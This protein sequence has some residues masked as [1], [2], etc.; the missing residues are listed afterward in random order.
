MPADAAPVSVA[1]DLETI[2]QWSPGDYLTDQAETGRLSFALVILNQPIVDAEG[3][4]KLWNNGKYHPH[5]FNLNLTPLSHSPLLITITTKYPG[6]A[7]IPDCI[8]GDLDSLQSR[9]GNYYRSLGVSIVPD[10]SQYATDFTKSLNWITK[11]ERLARSMAT[12][13][14]LDDADADDADDDDDDADSLRRR[15]CNLAAEEAISPDLG[16]TPLDVVAYGAT[17]GR[18]DQVFHAIDQLFRASHQVSAADGDEGDGSNSNSNYSN[19]NNTTS[20]ASSRRKLTLISDESVTF[21]L[22]RGKNI[23]D[24]P[25]KLFGKTCGLIPVAGPSVITTE[26]FEWDLSN[27]ETRFGGMVSTSN[28]LLKDRVEVVTTELLLFTMEIR[29]A[30]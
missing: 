17:G 21:M 22:E 16:P 27:T 3:F 6:F 7:L 13:A 20:D 19:N 28:H 4:T 10:R 23:V 12:S 9:V 18:V 5:S 1:M 2:T 25:L 8:T 26:G 24:T 15:P 11:Q 30:R 14:A 29:K